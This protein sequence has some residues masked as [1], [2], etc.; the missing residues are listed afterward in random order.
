MIDFD[1]LTRS[2]WVNDKY[3]QIVADYLESKECVEDEYN[4]SIRQ[5]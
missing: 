1:N 2:K 4:D 5:E 3:K